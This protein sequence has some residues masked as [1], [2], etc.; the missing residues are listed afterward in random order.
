MKMTNRPANTGLSNPYST[1]GGGVTFEQLVG[2]SYLVSL[3]VGEIPRGVDWG[4]IKEV[5]FQHRWSGCLLDDI[6]VTSTDGDT[7]RKLALQ[8]KKDLTFSESD[9]TLT[10][11]MNDCWKTFNSSLGWE[12]DQETDRLGIGIGVYQT[13]VDKHL[14][15]LLEWA[16][17]SK[18]SSEFLQK[19]SLPNFSSG[20]K[21][22]YCKIIRNLISKSKGSD[23]TDDEIWKFLRCLVVI[24]FDLENDG[25]RDSV[26]C[27]NRL[28]DQL[29][30][31][32]E[33]QAI[34]LFNTL[35]SIVA[36]YAR[37]AGSI[38]ASTLRT[39]IPSSITLKDHPNF[40]SDIAKLRKHTDRVLESIP[41]TI[42]GKVRLPR[43][44]LLDLIETS[45]E[46][47][48]VVVI[49]GEPMRGKSVLLKLLANRLRSEGEIIALSVER[50]SGT[51][52][53]SF[54]HDINIQKDFRNIL[55]AMGMAP[56]RCIL[57]DG[58][59]RVRG[60]EDRRR[61]LNDLIIEVRKY[62]K[63]VLAKGGHQDNCWKIVFACRE[64]D[65]TD[66]LLHLETRN[67]LADKSLETVKVGSLSDDEVAEVVDQLPKLKEL[68]SQ[69]HLKEIL[70]FPLVLDILTL[71]DI[72]L[73]SEEVPPILTETWLLD[74]FWKEVVRLAE[75]SR[76]GGGNPDTREQLLIR[77]ARQSVGGDDFIT[78]SDDM[79][80][81]AVSGLV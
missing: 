21:R 4:T 80:S 56:L 27:W 12:F 65:A 32:D 8:V 10:R 62:N 31:R 49:I 37:S 52:I 38:D 75:G 25:S 50:F 22:E 14:R 30:N 2:T 58:L 1:G 23:V 26:Y 17:T 6:V 81:E 76:S 18:D 36:E 59:E 53:E 70:S 66:V 69:G 28:L 33:G 71:P 29:K 19:V 13:K 67:N 79:D 64:L 61:V 72:S 3:L 40:T 41:N 43:N 24:H 73:T 44:E 9:P 20:P 7:E 74:W 34:S 68:A 47:N 78:M 42:G 77:I 15:P 11:V 35:T 54:L 45:I 5:K 57:I 48:D 51:T 16:R 63:S 46:G 60:D 39:K 55:F